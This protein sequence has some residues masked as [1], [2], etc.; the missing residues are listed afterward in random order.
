VN[1][2]ECTMHVCF[3]SITQRHITHCN[4][5]SKWRLRCQSLRLMPKCVMQRGR[6]TNQSMRQVSIRAPAGHICCELRATVFTRV[7]LSARLRHR[8]SGC[9]RWAARFRTIVSNGVVWR[10]VDWL[11]HERGR[12]LIERQPVTHDDGAATRCF[13]GPSTSSA[14]R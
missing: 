9:R 5:L 11:R 2:T 8:S 13:Q 6:R 14:G 7:C 3:P 4:M 1:L 12:S 10:G